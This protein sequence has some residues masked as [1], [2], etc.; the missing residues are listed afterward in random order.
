MMPLFPVLRVGEL[1]KYES[2]LKKQSVPISG[3][4][5]HSQSWDSSALGGM[6]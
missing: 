1:K 2:G 3:C 5:R 4:L 6:S